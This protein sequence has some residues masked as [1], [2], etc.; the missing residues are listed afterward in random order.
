MSLKSSVIIFTVGLG[1]G[2]GLFRGVSTY[3]KT[4]T[5]T[6]SETSI[7]EQLKEKDK[8]IQQYKDTISNI[9]QN[10]ITTTTET[11]KPDGTKVVTTKID[12]SKKIDTDIKKGTD[13]NVRGIVDNK[14]EQTKEET[15]TESIESISSPNFTLGVSEIQPVSATGFNFNPSNT[16]ITMGYRI[17]VLPAFMTIGTTPTIDFYNHLSLGVMVEF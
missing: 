13:T 1:L 15:K 10:N 11:T 6:T 7:T 17:W 3:K 5:D 2:V 14:G 4:T 16:T 12:K 8:E 9:T